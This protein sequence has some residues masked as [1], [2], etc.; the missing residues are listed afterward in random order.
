MPLKA[1]VSEN[2]ATLENDRVLLKIEIIDGSF[3]ERIFANNDGWQPLLESRPSGGEP[4]L[5]FVPTA[6]TCKI[7]DQS[8]HSAAL[9][10]TGS[11][12]QQ[13][14]NV[15]IRLGKDDSFLHYSVQESVSGRMRTRSLMSRYAFAENEV[16]FC[17]VPHLRPRHDHV[18]GQFA[19]K[20]P[21][22]IVQSGSKLASLIADVDKIETSGQQFVCLEP[23]MSRQR[24]PEPIIAYGFKD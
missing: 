21:A 13:T 16:D 14:F 22:I 9:H 12:G 23:D 6:D 20:S 2:T 4:S 17:F 10:L 18:V 5:D 8:A 15:T 24:F 19:F 1:E 11:R 7:L 3:R